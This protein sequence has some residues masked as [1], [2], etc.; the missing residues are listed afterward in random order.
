MVYETIIYEKR[1]SIACITLNRPR[2]SH[3]I[4]ARMAEELRDVCTKIGED[5]VIKAVIITGAGEEYFS[6]GSELE[7][8]TRKREG[9]DAG[10][11]AELLNRH[12]VAQYIAQL[13]CP[14]IAAINGDALG[15]G[16]EL[17]LSCDIRL[18]VE[19]ATLGL[20]Q[21]SRGIIPWDGGTQRLARI[22]GRGKAVEM[23]LL[24][25]PIDAF[26][27]QRVGL[28]SKVVPSQELMS[29]ARDIA[30]RICSFGPIGVRYAKEAVNKGMD[31]TLEQGLRLEADLY[32]IT[33]TTDDR[34]E[35]IRAFLEKRK[36][37]FKGR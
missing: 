8:L 5:E 30:E 18:A 19:K 20:E 34:A 3:A 10:T 37:R 9:L 36:P 16:L 12:R 1:G 22:V 24:G 29:Q 21:V 14:V 31:L 27:A 6:S 7:G 33:Q 11:V 17:T 28:V 32:I 13:E 35:G 15:Q 4:N 2:F 25:K 23:I 26:E